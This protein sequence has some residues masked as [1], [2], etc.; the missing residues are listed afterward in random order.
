MVPIPAAVSACKKRPV[1]PLEV[2]QMASVVDDRN[3][4]RPSQV[5][6]IPSQVISPSI[7][8]GGWVFLP[9]R[10]PTVVHTTVLN[11]F[12]QVGRP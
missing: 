3:V 9:E 11:Q 5:K 6:R 1:G 10:V 4:G 2:D 12:L 7:S 8:I